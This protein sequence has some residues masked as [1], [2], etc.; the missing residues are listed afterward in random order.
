MPDPGLFEYVSAEFKYY[1]AMCDLLD[2]GRFRGDQS[3]REVIQEMRRLI[4]RQKVMTR[5]D[6]MQRFFGISKIV[7]EKIRE[8]GNTR[9]CVCSMS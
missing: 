2:V 1:N 3:T 8:D 6:F 9:K 7:R 4:D 5:A